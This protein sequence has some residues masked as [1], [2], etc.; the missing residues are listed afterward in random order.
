MK[1]GVLSKRTGLSHNMRKE[2]GFPSACAALQVSRTE[3]MGTQ[4]RRDADRAGRQLSARGR[5]RVGRAR[6]ARQRPRCPLWGRGVRADHSRDRLAAVAAIG[7]SRPPGRSER[8]IEH[9][10]SPTGIVTVSVG[11][12]AAGPPRGQ[13]PDSLVRAADKA[14]YRAKDPGRDRVET[15]GLLEQV[16]LD[17]G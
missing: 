2:H 11:V 4:S 12:A 13:G 17:A 3:G 6:A 7:G 1:P 5:L 15:A 9:A 10:K 8:A 16:S 14:L